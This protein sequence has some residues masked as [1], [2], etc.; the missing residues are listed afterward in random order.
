RKNRSRITD[1]ASLEQ[2]AASWNEPVSTLAVLAGREVRLRAATAEPDPFR[3]AAARSSSPLL[4]H[5]R[6]MKR[7]FLPSDGRRPEE[8]NV[9]VKP[10]ARPVPVMI[11][12][13]QSIRPVAPQ[14]RAPTNQPEGSTSGCADEPSQGV[15]GRVRRRAKPRGPRS[16][17]P[18]SQPHSGSWWGARG[19]RHRSPRTRSLELINAGAAAAILGLE[20]GAVAVA[21]VA[22]RLARLLRK[23]DVHGLGPSPRVECGPRGYHERQARARVPLRGG[24]SAP[25]GAPGAQVRATPWAQLSGRARRGGPGR[26]GHRL[27]HRLPA[28]LRRVDAARLAPR[29]QLPE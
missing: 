9:R 19:E 23:D 29:P 13:R 27:V 6:R 18:T 5:P 21:L 8:P 16:G 15:H 2:P 22:I 12:S 17:A 20:L 14:S 1:S 28:P 25:E 24:P 4:G 7:R 10:R 3:L 26:P 11:G